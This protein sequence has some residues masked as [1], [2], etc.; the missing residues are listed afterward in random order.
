MVRTKWGRYFSIYHYLYLLLH[1]VSFE[2]E[3]TQYLGV[4]IQC[5]VWGAGSATTRPRCPPWG[6][7]TAPG[8]P[9]SPSAA[10][11]SFLGTGWGLS[12]R[13]RSGP[14]LRPRTSAPSP[15]TASSW[16]VESVVTTGAGCYVV[17]QENLP[18][19]WERLCNGGVCYCNDRDGC[20]SAKKLSNH[21]GI[22]CL[23]TLIFLYSS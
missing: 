9:R 12:R 13:M 22:I 2:L 23:S 8:P 3:A 6:W 21:I 19:W 5:P 18:E 20:N 7:W 11:T 14:V 17:W 1:N 16:W 15:R 10:S 4:Q